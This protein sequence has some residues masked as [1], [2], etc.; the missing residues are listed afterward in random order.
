MTE[1]HRKKQE[2]VRESE[3]R[4][5]TMADT[6]PVLIWT[7]D[8]DKLCTYVS[9]TWLDLTGR[10]FEEELGC[11]WVDDIHP[12]DR[13]VRLEAYADCFDRRSPF[14]VEYRVRRHDGEYRWLLDKGA[15]RFA[16][17]G[18]FL[19][20]IGSATD[21]TER[22][23]AEERLRVQHTVA[24]ILAEAATIEEVTPRI[25]RA[26]GECLEWDAGALW[27]VDRQ[28]EALRC[29]ELWH[30]A[31]IE[32]PEFER[33]SRESTFVTGLGLPAGCGPVLR[34]NTL[35]MSFLMETSR[36]DPPPNAKDC[37]RPSAFPSCSGGKPWA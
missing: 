33:V 17:D 20:Y 5:R 1:E 36:A 11:G 35:P 24:Q 12:S 34:P 15:P 7:T 6:A 9:Q 4:F 21:I 18:T 3:E 8:A 31:S 19:G 22:K 32:V 28:A 14:T 25:L 2:S 23:R 26:I 16:S 30:K 29:V 13:G 27:R 37:T 10:M